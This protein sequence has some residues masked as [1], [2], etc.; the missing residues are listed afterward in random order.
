MSEWIIP[1]VILS[2]QA[3][4]LWK[5]FHTLWFRQKNIKLIRRTI[6]WRNRCNVEQIRGEGPD[7][8]QG[9]YP[10][11]KSLGACLDIRLRISEHGGRSLE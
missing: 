6:Y 11:K 2:D 5:R 10:G 7:A 3:L 8:D 1:F 9:G 4:V